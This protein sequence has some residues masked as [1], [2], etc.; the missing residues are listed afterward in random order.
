MNFMKGRKGRFQSTVLFAAIALLCVLAQLPHTPGYTDYSVLQAQVNLKI[1]NVT[2]NASYTA[3]SIKWTAGTL[4]SGGHAVS[5][6]AG[7]ATLTSLQ[8]N[9]VAP[10]YPA[11][12]ILWA[13]SSG[14]VSVTATSTGIATAAATGNSIMAYIETSSTAITRVVYP[15]QASTAQ[16]P[17]SLRIDCGTSAACASPT[18]VVAALRAAGGA[19]TVST[20][21]AVIITNILPAFTS[22][23]TYGCTATIDGTTSTLR[24]SSYSRTSS[25]SITLFVA[26]VAGSETVTWNCAGY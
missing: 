2:S 25:S 6:T 22:T 8:N 24:T 26:G 11:C 13:N 7:S 4:D 18:S 12:N 5:V 20:T 3:L 17:N 9:C 23:S 15:P 21:S 19:V 10:T 14:T 1:P 16:M